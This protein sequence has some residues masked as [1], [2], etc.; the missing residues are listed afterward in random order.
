MLVNGVYRQF[1]D[2]RPRIFQHCPDI[3][4]CGQ[5]KTSA[6]TMNVR[7]WTAE[8]AL[9]M[10]VCPSQ[11]FFHT[12]KWIIFFATFLRHWLRVPQRGKRTNVFNALHIV[13]LVQIR[14]TCCGGSARYSEDLFKN[15]PTLAHTVSCFPFPVGS[16]KHQILVCEQSANSP[17]TRT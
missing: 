4:L 8:I 12:I 9:P 11:Y 13:L 5:A 3:P 14:N 6:L 15:T 16:K 7:V 2:C 17:Q 1:A 10:P